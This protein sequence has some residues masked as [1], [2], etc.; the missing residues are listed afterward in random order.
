MRGFSDVRIIDAMTNDLTGDALAAILADETPGLIG[1]AAIPPSTD[2]AERG[3]Q[4][5]STFTGARSIF[6][7]ECGLYRGIIHMVEGPGRG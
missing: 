3:F 4:G 2:K 1:A 7:V 5:I 6:R